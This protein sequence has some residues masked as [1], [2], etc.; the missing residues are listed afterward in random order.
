M[1]Q[2]WSHKKL[3]EV[4]VLQRGF[5]LPKG[6]RKSGL[7]PLISSSGRSDYHDEAK[8]KGPGVVTGRSGSIGKVFFIEEDFWPLNTT[9]Y[10]KEFYGNYPRFVA[11]LLNSFDLSRYTSGA[12]VPTLNR[13]HVHDELVF[14]PESVEEQKRIV[15]ILDQTFADLDQARATAETNLKNARELFDS[16]L[17]QVFSQR[18]EGWVEA[19]LGDLLDIG[20]SKR[21][22][23]TDWTKSGVP[24]FGGKEIVQLAKYGTVVSNAYISEEKY[25]EYASK[26]DM[27]KKG[28]ILMTARGTIGVGYIVQEGD[29]FY[30]KDGN[31]IS[32]RQKKPTNPQFILYAFKTKQILDQIER[33]TGTTVNH[34]P[35]RAAKEIVLSIP[36]YDAQNVIVS[37]IKE[38][39]T[40]IQHLV[41][42]YEKKLLAVDEL[43]KSILQKAFTGELTKSK[44]IAA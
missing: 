23:E 38:M 2:G 19:K 26:Y 22:Y 30:Y 13:N 7:V 36:N 32:L 44:G 33:L 11:Y 18:G 37:K 3:G 5:D 12:G 20:S 34:L 42:I 28:D 21:I 1:T 27:P 6:Y 40:N 8:V 39:E 41:R 25:L 4:C 16:Y 24:F 31:I 17:Q 29:K 9:L 10:V 35:L 43:K 14:V 15:A